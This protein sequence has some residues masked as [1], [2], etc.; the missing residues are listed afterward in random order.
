M[1]RLAIAASL[2]GLTLLRPSLGSHTVYASAAMT[3]ST[4]SS[5]KLGSNVDA[6]NPAEDTQKGQ[7][8]VSV[9]ATGRYVVEA[10][11][12]AT[13]VS[14]GWPCGSAMNK[15]EAIGF[16]FSADGG[17]SFTDEGGL[18]NP[19]CTSTFKYLAD[20]SVEAW[21]PG[22]TARFYISG[23][24]GDPSPGGQDEIA[25]DA[26]QATGKGASATITC[27][28]PLIVASVAP[29]IPN[30][31][32]E[33]LDKDFLAIDPVRGR[34]YVSYTRVGPAGSPLVNGRIELAVCDIGT[35]SGGT[36]PAGG[37][38]G[39]PVCFP[40]TSTTPYFVVA[41]AD[42]NCDQGGAYPAVDTATGDVYVAWE[43]N[44]RH[45]LPALAAKYPACQPPQTVR[46]NVAFVPSGCLTLTPASPC[47]AG[48]ALTQAVVVTSMAGTPAP[49]YNLTV[50]NDYPRIA[51]SDPKGTVSIVWN[52][53]RFHP[54]GNILLQSF[55]LGSLAPVQATPVQIDKPVPSATGSLNTNWHIMPAM[56]Q[57]S[58]DGLLTV[59]FYGGRPSLGTTLTDVFV[60][61][62]VDPRTKKT[63]HNKRVTN[64]SS[65]WSTVTSVIAPNFG[66]YTDNYIVP[67][68]NKVHVA[69]TD[70]RL[71]I[72]QPFDSR[73]HAS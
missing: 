41:P 23:L 45:H 43:F 34:L 67:G 7:A 10:W 17:V 27:S 5:S 13:G 46:N 68:T 26:C 36:G 19:L 60:A 28:S 12:D 70:D 62:G 72:P 71:G 8:E 40:G 58:E 69:W 44:R 31:A 14:G 33:L 9:A 6:A 35:R 22:G 21:S 61:K 2:V 65:D 49:G 52:D 59:S 56:R 51:V 39:K 47:P 11:N 3:S 1:L 73:K 38:A 20:P 32:G 15:E 55:T 57:A 25:L 30:T 54:D 53:A 37:T 18:P 29:T 42:P 24:I 50:F 64:M 48:S 66:D 16:G 63:P 4:T